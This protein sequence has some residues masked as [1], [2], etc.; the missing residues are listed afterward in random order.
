MEQVLAENFSFKNRA[1]P[2]DAPEHSGQLLIEGFKEP[3]TARTQQIIDMDLNDLKATVLQSEKLVRAAA[4]GV[5]PE[6]MRRRASLG[7]INSG[8]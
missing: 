5:D 3:T 6:V 1:K 8:R 4:A 7:S 2:G